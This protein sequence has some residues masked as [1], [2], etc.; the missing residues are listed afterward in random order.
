MKASALFSVIILG[1]MLN[2]QSQGWVLNH[3][4][5]D[6]VPFY[7]WTATSNGGASINISTDEAHSG[8]QS[9]YLTHFSSM[10]SLELFQQL[11]FLPPPG[12]YILEFWMKGSVS[13]NGLKLEVLGWTPELQWFHLGDDSQNNTQYLSGGSGS[14]VLNS[15]NYEEWT[16]ISFYFGHQNSMVIKIKFSDLVFG[17]VMAYFDDFEIV[18]ASVGLRENRNN[19]IIISPN[20]ADNYFLIGMENNDGLPF[21]VKL[22]NSSGQCVKSKA[23]VNSA[24]SHKFFVEDLPNGLYYCQISSIQKQYSRKFI[25]QH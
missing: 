23:Y 19:Q 10:S 7:Y 20:P 3:S 4:F 12:E 11:A 14:A 13:Y 1:L 5:E 24:N 18:D 25:I 9:A 21:D 6:P 2:V 17:S 8:D 22:F 16:K 15:A